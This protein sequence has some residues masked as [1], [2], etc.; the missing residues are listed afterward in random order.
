MFLKSKDVLS[1]E[2]IQNLKINSDIDDSLLRELFAL[3]TK[4]GKKEFANRMH[5]FTQSAI[6]NQEKQQGT[7]DDISAF[8]EK[9]KVEKLDLETA[10]ENEKFAGLVED[11]E[12]PL[13][14]EA[15]GVLNQPVTNHPTNQP[16][17]PSTG[18]AVRAGHLLRV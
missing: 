16:T 17:N 10:E 18:A 14:L 11:Q 2:N 4:V 15:G 13:S 1:P 6:G 8:L 5:D 9:L 3:S 12:L 7:I